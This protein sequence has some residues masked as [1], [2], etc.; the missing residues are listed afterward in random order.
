MQCRI[1]RINIVKKPKRFTAFTIFI[2]I[3]NSF[4]KFPLNLDLITFIIGDGRSEPVLLKF[5]CF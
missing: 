3:D 5:K 1:V 4:D 2:Q